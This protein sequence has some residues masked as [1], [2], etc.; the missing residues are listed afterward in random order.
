MSKAK[1]FT[2]VYSS[3]LFPF[4]EGP[5]VSLVGD[6]ESSPLGDRMKLGKCGQDPAAS[7]RSWSDT[8]SPR[9]QLLTKA[10]AGKAST[11]AP[12]GSCG[13]QTHLHA[14]ATS[15]PT[16]QHGSYLPPWAAKIP[17]C[18]EKT[19][20]QK[21]FEREVLGSDSLAGLRPGQEVAQ[22]ISWSLD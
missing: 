3:T 4:N 5:F 13:H 18:I 1:P 17:L 10:L 12:P 20:K 16:E 7:G 11:G 14:R 9:L 15:H 6:V 2:P 8:S 22:S 21:L 19:D